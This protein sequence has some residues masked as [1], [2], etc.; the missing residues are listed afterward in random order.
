LTDPPAVPGKVRIRIR[1]LDINGNA[2]ASKN[3][4]ID[5]GP[6]TIKAVTDSDGVLQVDVS[7]RDRG[8]SLTVEL[9]KKA[10]FDPVISLVLRPPSAGDQV[11]GLKSRLN[12]LG[13]LAVEPVNLGTMDAPASR[14][15]DRF[16]SANG[17]VD[18]NGLPVGPTAAPFDTAT[19]DRLENAHDTRG[20]LVF[21]PPP[22]P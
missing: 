14:A 15:L 21:F 11:V 2:L 9:F 13:Y 16:R 6:Q 1:L 19:K 7:S 20:K 17:L 3:C 10:G 12:N 4:T 22:S 5:W 18:A 8:G